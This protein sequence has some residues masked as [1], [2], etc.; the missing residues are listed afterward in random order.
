LVLRQSFVSSGRSQPNSDMLGT[1][2]NRVHVHC[3][4]VHPN[5]F[6]DLPAVKVYP[7]QELMVRNKIAK[8]VTNE[9]NDFHYN[10]KFRTASVIRNYFIRGA[11]KG[12]H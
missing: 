6:D 12:V 10:I 5:L 11:A 2:N 9:S 3:C 7:F 4:E 1:G 8:L